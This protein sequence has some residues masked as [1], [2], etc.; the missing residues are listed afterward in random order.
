[1]LTSI[2]VKV[3]VFITFAC[4]SAVS[5]SKGKLVVLIQSCFRNGGY[6]KKAKLDPRK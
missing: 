1:M 2:F 6:Y 5:G 3:R 4:I